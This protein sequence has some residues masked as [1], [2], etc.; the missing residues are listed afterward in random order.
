MNTELNFTDIGKRIQKYRKNKNLT[1]TA[2]AEMIGTNQ[3]HLSRI[4]SGYHK[5]SFNTIAA[6][7]SSLNIP[8]DALIADMDDSSNASTLKIILDNV[9]GMNSKQLQ[10]LQENIHT[11]K[12]F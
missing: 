6:I 12:K 10:M 11:I 9:K 5:S 8:I 3:K 2:L 4:E 7:A 1:Q